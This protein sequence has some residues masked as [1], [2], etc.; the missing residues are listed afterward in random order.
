[1]PPLANT[2]EVELLSWRAEILRRVAQGQPIG[3]RLR[4]LFDI[5]LPRVLTGTWL[6]AGECYGYGSVCA[7]ALHL[8]P[9]P[10]YFQSW[11]IARTPSL[12]F[13]K[14]VHCFDETT[15]R[16]HIQ[17]LATL[18]L[19]IFLRTV[20][21]TI[22]GSV[23]AGSYPAAQYLHQSKTKSYRPGDIDIF[24]FDSINAAVILELYKN[25]V[26]LPHQLCLSNVNTCGM[27]PVGLLWIKI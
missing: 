11:C 2:T 19:T 20:L 5:V 25:V 12:Q 18:R 24:H 13:C 22:D 10:T 26:A 21:E 15:R 14:Y 3:A 17:Y 4:S 23:V 6:T 1:M 7:A 16:F 9:A 8:E 27:N